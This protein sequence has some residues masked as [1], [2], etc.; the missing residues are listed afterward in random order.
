[1]LAL[2]CNI[3]LVKKK[4]RPVYNNFTWGPAAIKGIGNL[5]LIMCAD[6]SGQ[7]IGPDIRGLGFISG[8]GGGTVGTV[9]DISETGLDF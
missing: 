9:A 6:G 5:P 8:L 7:I 4:T 3:S 1:M 2:F